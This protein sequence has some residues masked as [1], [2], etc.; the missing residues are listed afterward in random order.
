MFFDFTNILFSKY[1]VKLEQ[2][3]VTSLLE[4]N[5]TI[6]GVQYKSKTGEELTKYA[7][8]TIVCDGCFSNL[9][10]SL[11]NPQVRSW[12]LKFMF[13]KP[14]Y[15]LKWSN[16]VLLEDL[17]QIVGIKCLLN[18]KS[19]VHHYSLL[20]TENDILIFLQVEVPSCFVGLILENCDL[21]YVNHG[22]VI[23]ADPSPILFYKISST[24]IRCLVDVPGQKVPSIS[25]GE[26]AKYL[27]SVVAPQ[28]YII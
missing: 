16:L 14:V 1:S 18:L 9:R 19:F 23:L 2:G 13:F 3:T 5:G 24:E 10:R 7:P 28:V 4:E 11:C 17:H 20:L 27:K 21:P 8:L 22:H 25:N 26:M 12:S 15:K 6:K